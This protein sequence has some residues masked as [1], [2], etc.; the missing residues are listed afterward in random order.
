MLVVHTGVVF[1]FFVCVFLLPND[2]P[3]NTGGRKKKE[4]RLMAQSLGD[5]FRMSNAEL[6]LCTAGYAVYLLA[7]NTFCCLNSDL[8]PGMILRGGIM[9]LCHFKIK[10]KNA[11]Q[12]AVICDHLGVT[13]GVTLSV[14]GHTNTLILFI[15]CLFVCFSVCVCVCFFWGGGGSGEVIYLFFVDG[16]ERGWGN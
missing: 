3:L 5:S 1:L 12:N 16:A 7:V 2:K 13:A 8:S 6:E 9:R 14:C 15:F 11:S 4:K 10:L